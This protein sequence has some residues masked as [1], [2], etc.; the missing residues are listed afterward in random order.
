PVNPASGNYVIGT[1]QFEQVEI[2][3]SDTKTF[4]IIAD[5]VSDENIYIKSVSLNGEPLER[6]YISHEEI[7]AGGELIFEMGSAPNKNW[8]KKTE[9]RPTN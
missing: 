2:T 5:G 7:I 3:L 8:A 4:T 9:Y 6:S 1:P